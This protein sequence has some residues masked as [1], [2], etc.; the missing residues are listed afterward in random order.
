MN[1]HASSLRRKPEDRQSNKAFGI[2]AT[3]HTKLYKNLKTLNRRMHFIRE[4]AC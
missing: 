1:M 4:I 2:Q 3:G